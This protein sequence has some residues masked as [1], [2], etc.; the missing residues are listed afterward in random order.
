[1]RIRVY[2]LIDYDDWAIVNNEIT[3]SLNVSVSS[4]GFAVVKAFIWYSDGG[5]LIIDWIYID[6]Y[7]NLSHIKQ[8][9]VY[10]IFAYIINNFRSMAFQENN[11]FAYILFDNHF[12]N[13]L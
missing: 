5:K 11:N 10:P 8:K 6:S 4:G 2:Q 9:H 1:M 3:V 7:R 13:V 12:G